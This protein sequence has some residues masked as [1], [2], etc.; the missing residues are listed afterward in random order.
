V[1][2]LDTSAL[3]KL[4]VREEHSHTLSDRIRA[5]GSPIPL[6]PFHDL[7]FTN[8]IQ[9]KCFRQELSEDKAAAVLSTIK[10]HE[11][12]G[13]YYRPPIDWA[14]VMALSIGMSRSHTVKIGSRSLDILHVA[15][16]LSIGMEQFIT[17]DER[18]NAL[19]TTVGLSVS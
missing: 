12:V 13:V 9:L 7:E 5:N 17:F 11:E 14:N 18:Q 16:A 15:F 8:A 2:D 3:I 19:A 4:Y 1:V 10:E 6:T